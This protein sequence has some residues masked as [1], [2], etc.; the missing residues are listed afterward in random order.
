MHSTVVVCWTELHAAM[1]QFIDYQEDK[2]RRWPHPEEHRSN[3]I[4][5]GAA[6]ALSSSVTR[7]LPVRASG[8]A[9][10]SSKDS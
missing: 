6:A 8:C 4:M 3:F 10:M 1:V 2:Q 9:G 7:Q 5:A